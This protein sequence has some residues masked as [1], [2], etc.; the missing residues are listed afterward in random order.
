M[1]TRSYIGIQNADGSVLGI[2]CHFDGY[3]SHHG[4]ILLL[5]YNTEAMVRALI[6]L[7]DISVLADSLGEKHD[8]DNRPRGACN[9]YG[10]DRG[11]ENT[12][13]VKFESGAAFFAETSEGCDYV[14]LFKDSMWFVW[15]RRFGTSPLVVEY[16]KDLHAM[17]EAQHKSPRSRSR[18]TIRR[19]E[20]RIRRASRAH[21]VLERGSHYRIYRKSE[22]SPLQPSWDL[23]SAGGQ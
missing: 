1:S 14:Y 11:E 8:F 21:D 4:R 10:R 20:A 22:F 9:A 3:P 16:L 5:H 15:G 23:A 7:G 19:M 13:A 17:G 2:Y 18:R 6:A 12:A